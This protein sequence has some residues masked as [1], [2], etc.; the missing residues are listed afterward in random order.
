MQ[1]QPIV[2]RNPEHNLLLFRLN[3]HNVLS[4]QVEREPLS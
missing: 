2:K 4:G 3:Y 1:V